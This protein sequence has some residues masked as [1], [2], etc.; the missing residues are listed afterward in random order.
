MTTGGPHSWCQRP[1]SRVNAPIGGAT[2]PRLSLQ[3]DPQAG[4]SSRD[5]RNN[6]GN[7]NTSSSRPTR[8]APGSGGSHPSRRCAATGCCS[9]SPAGPTRATSACPY[10]GRPS[11]TS[12]ASPTSSCT[13]RCP[14]CPARTRSSSASRSSRTTRR[15]RTSLSWARAG[16]WTRS[17]DTLG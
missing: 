11:T 6:S 5:P 1:T 4:W 7:A 9:P 16:P 2:L 3:C 13:S 17:D 15:I 8:N 10:R 14:H 12:R